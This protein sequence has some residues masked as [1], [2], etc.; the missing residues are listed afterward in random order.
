M[1]VSSSGVLVAQLPPIAP[2]WHLT[3]RTWTHRI[4]A[5]RLVDGERI[6][7]D[8]PTLVGKA[9][10][11]M[12][13]IT[14]G[15]GTVGY[16]PLLNWIRAHVQEQH[17]P[18]KEGW[19][20]CMCTGN[21]DGFQRAWETLLDPGDS[22]LVDELDFSFST[23]QLSAWVGAR[24]LHIEPLVADATL[25][26]P[27]ALSAL[28][29]DWA[30]RRPGMRFP[31]AYFTIP[32][33]QNPT[34]ITRTRAEM[35]ALYEVV[36]DFGMLLIED[37]PYR[38]LA[39]GDP[40]DAAAPV[41]GYR[42]EAGEGL[43][44]SYLSLDRE[45]RVLRCDTFSKWMGPG[46]RCGWVTAPRQVIHKLA[47]GVG[48]SLGVASCV[49]V[50][51]HAILTRWGAAGLDAHVS[52]VQAAYK[53]RAAVVLRAAAEHL[54][55]LAQWTAPR[56]GMFVWMKLCGVEDA[57]ALLDAMT[58]E[59]VL[60]VPGAY[61]HGLESAPACPFVR[62]SFALASDEVRAPWHHQALFRGITSL[63]SSPLCLLAFL[64]L[65]YSSRAC[66]AWGQC[67]AASTPPSRRSR[68]PSMRPR[69]RPGPSAPSSTPLPQRPPRRPP[70]L[71]AP[72]PPP[73]PRPRGSGRP[74]PR[75]MRV[76][77][78]FWL[79]RM[80]VCGTHRSSRVFAAAERR[81]VSEIASVYGD[82]TRSCVRTN[83][84]PTGDS[85]VRKRDGGGG[86]ETDR[87]SPREW[88][89]RSGPKAQGRTAGGTE[90]PERGQPRGKRSS[91]S[92]SLFFLDYARLRL[93][94]LWL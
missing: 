37:D 78:S 61:F 19:D 25:S 33:F 4:G 1:C 86:E 58:A 41:P 69:R 16:V 87:A 89:D 32:S 35:S 39:F 7:I 47:Q 12:H 67:C 54:A 13:D 18:P 62:I 60:V 36:C 29:G 45:G 15:V 65:R 51:L 77:N 83:D 17:A 42:G 38:F 88:R 94:I 27:A 68:T 75:L 49:Q 46:L 34:C 22:L 84:A 59:K 74:P 9:Q 63:T 82:A 79:Y 93:Y 44:S 48:P 10:Q 24:G 71:P 6:C 55:G 91:F 92:S 31:K 90:P 66:A 43:P 14:P 81:G 76:R 64:L 11:Y 57:A 26:A 73:K 5:P 40:L 20:V 3:A 53:H 23:S 50:Q 52:R 30:R 8:D 56:G 2:T 28:L 70:P 80:E 72:P 85:S 21:A